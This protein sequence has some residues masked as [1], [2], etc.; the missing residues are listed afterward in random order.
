MGLSFNGDLQI[1]V[2]VDSYRNQMANVREP[3]ARWPYCVCKDIHTCSNGLTEMILQI[4][5]QFLYDFV[6]ISI[7]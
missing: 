5:E 3:P 2:I 6:N 7:F 4:L 1:I